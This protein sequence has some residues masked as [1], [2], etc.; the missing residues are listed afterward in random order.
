MT[1]T[2]KQK[3][4]YRD[5]YNSHKEQYKVWRTNWMASNPNNKVKAANN[6]INQLFIK[7]NNRKMNKAEQKQLDALIIVLLEAHRLYVSTSVNRK[8]IISKRVEYNGEHNGRA[9]E[10]N[11]K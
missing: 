8:A 10:D 5:Y 9:K 4:Y 2:D 1:L 7:T 6:Q 11:T 3:Q